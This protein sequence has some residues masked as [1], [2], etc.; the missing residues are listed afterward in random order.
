[1]NIKVQ[2]DDCDWWYH[3]R[4]INKKIKGKKYLKEEAETL[5]FHGPCCTVDRQFKFIVHSYSK[6][7]CFSN[8]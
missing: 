2:C 7:M 3:L 6:I 4:C 1:M 5:S 8:S